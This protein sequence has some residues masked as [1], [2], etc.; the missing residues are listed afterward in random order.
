MT[1]SLPRTPRGL[2][3]GGGLW[4]ILGHI[5]EELSRWNDGI[6]DPSTT[7]ATG[8]RSPAQRV[9]ESA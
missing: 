9:E 2:G 3:S 4:T 7:V 1:H 6:P 5:C 8:H